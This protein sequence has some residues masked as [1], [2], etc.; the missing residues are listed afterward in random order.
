MA[1]PNSIKRNLIDKANSTIVAATAGASFVVIFCLVASVTLIGQFSY[2]S[3]VIAANKAAR[4]TLKDDIVAAQSLGNSYKAFTSTTQN[5]IGGDPNGTGARDGNNAKIVLDA[6]PSKYDYP[7][8]VTS[9][10]KILSGQ[11]VTIKSIGGTDDILSQANPVSSSAPTP[12][13]MPFQLTVTGDYNSV[14]KVVEAFEKSIR[15]INV[16]T[17]ALNSEQNKI[18]MIVTAKT[19]FQPAKN[20]N[21]RTEVVK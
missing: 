6:L 17:L 19:Y 20:L 2:Q 16:Q 8:L 9:M 1:Q 13:E 4:K 21:I 15:P 12:Q 3:R 5:V 10:E 14:R 7:A 18:T 11:N